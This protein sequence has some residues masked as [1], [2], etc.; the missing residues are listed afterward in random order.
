[1]KKISLYAIAKCP[2]TAS[3]E[4]FLNH[5]CTF[6]SRK[7]DINEYITCKI[8]VEN[9]GHYKQWMEIHYPGKE[10]DEENKLEYLHDVVGE[11]AFKEYGVKKITYNRD[12]LA[13]AFR[14]LNKCIPVGTSYETPAEVSTIADYLEALTKFKDAQKEVN[15][16]ANQ[17]N[18]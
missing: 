6:V 10:M 7:K 11:D 14:L 15:K 4:E 5:L 9:Y 17:Q 1:M 2:S 18:G 12:G 3:N 16:D 8:F 13:A